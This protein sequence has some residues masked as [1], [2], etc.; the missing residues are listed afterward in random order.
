[1]KK[2]L[3]LLLAGAVG[4]GVWR[5]YAQEHADRDLWADVTDAE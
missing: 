1:M 2:V 3:A 5:W 4:Y